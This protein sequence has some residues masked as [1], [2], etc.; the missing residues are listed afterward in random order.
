[1]AVTLAAGTRLLC[2]VGDNAAMKERADQLVAVT[3]EHSFPHWRSQGEI[4][5][6]WAKIK[7]GDLAEGRALLQSGSAAYRA[8]G[9]GMFRPHYTAL[10][11]T[12]CEIARQ[13]DEALVLL[14]EALQI[15]ERTGERWLEAELHRHKGQLLLRQGQP[16]AAEELYRKALSIFG[17]RRPSSGNCAPL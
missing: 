11:A 7:D 4:Y 8:T 12:A 9:A 6:G 15:T 2:L 3:T 1:L 16:E 14:D 5:R 10:L 13:V 17:S